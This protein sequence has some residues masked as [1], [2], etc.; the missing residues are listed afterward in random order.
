M[1][2]PL[3]EINKLKVNFN[4]YY[5]LAKVLD[6]EHL[7][8][9]K[10]ETFGLAGE[11]GS[12][13]SITALSIF[14]L[15]PCPP[16]EIE[17]GEIFYNGE[18]LLTKSEKE[19]R[20]IRG[21]KLSMIFQDPMSSLNPVFTVG[22]QIKRVI[23][24]HDKV[25][26]KQAEARALELF[27]LVKLPDPKNTMDKY[28][29]E[30]SGGMRQRVIIAM[31]LSCGAEFLIADEPTRALDVTIQAGVLEL[32]KEIK[33]ETDL[34]MLFIAN[35]LGVISEMCERVALLYAGQIVET[36]RVEDVFRNP[37]HPY[38]FALIEAVPK[39]SQ[40]D[41]PLSV[42]G[43]FPP[44]PIKMP[45]GCR[46]NPRCPKAAELCINKKPIMTEVEK[47]HWVACHNWGG[48]I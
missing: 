1:T 21:K 27:D 26:K 32:I 6:L 36:G 40:K 39:P 8:V 48:G 2:K 45:Q 35:S 38:T 12:G 5:G 46:F 41:K 34:T 15:L 19:M 44:D 22:E 16:G 7:F 23:V 3:L 28:P 18:N 33:R 42:T 13:K 14:N 17:S 47:G 24:H 20:Q 37:L 4:T 31:A 43:G 29:H 10:G 30:L 11:S 25:A 9:E